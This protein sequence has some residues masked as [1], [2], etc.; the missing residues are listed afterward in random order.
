MQINFEV[1]NY[2]ILF[3]GTYWMKLSLTYYELYGWHIKK[4]WIQRSYNVDTT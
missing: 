4:I 2:V 3:I 1:Y